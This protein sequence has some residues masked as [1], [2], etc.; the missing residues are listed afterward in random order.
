[1]K[2]LMQVL[3]LS[4]FIIITMSAGA[5][6][7]KL[8]ES[9]WKKIDELI[10]KKNLPKSA[11]AEVKKLYIKV[12]AEK[13]DAQIIKALVYM[14][15]LQQENREENQKLA[16]K[17]IE[18][19][20][21]VHKEPAASILKSLLASLYLQYFQQQRWQ[22][23]NRSATVNFAKE[24]VATWTTEDF[25]KKIGDLYLQSIGQE[26]L[27]QATSLEAYSAIINKGNVRHLRPTLYD[28]LAHQALQY[29]QSSERTVKKPAY[30]FEL[31]D[32]KA[33]APAAV[34]AAHRFKTDDSLSLEF[35]A[36]QIYQKLIGLHLKDA[37]QDALIDV[38]IQRIQF[39]NGA[40]TMGDKEAFYVAALNEIIARHKSRS[41][42]AQAAYLVALY[43]EGFATQYHP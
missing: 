18:N 40:A 22:L 33:F 15:S 13:Q 35:K 31:T 29:F 19:E 4:F 43:H 34:F 9:D 12:K 3:I 5:Q 36:L 28:L 21:A 1:M 17:E 10:Q 7:I 27:L 25:H 6:N 41:A 24:D 39:V 38:D 20:L 42:T 16:I 2:S 26:K 11:L 37:R 32:V 8:Y 23:Y 30:A 14:S